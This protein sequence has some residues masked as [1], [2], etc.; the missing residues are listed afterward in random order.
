MKSN[1]LSQSLL[2]RPGSSSDGCTVAERKSI[3]F[4]VDGESLLQKLVKADGGHADFM[5]CFVKG[6]PEQNAMSAEKLIVRAKPDTDS[7]RVLFY[8]CPECGDI[9][10]G[11]YSARVTKADDCYTWSDFAYENGYEDARPIGGVGPFSFEASEY[12]K[13]IKDAAAL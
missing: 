13:S 1:T 8:I 6:L 4:L 3:D 10:C 11:A 7:G 12:E 5:G 9:G 2:F